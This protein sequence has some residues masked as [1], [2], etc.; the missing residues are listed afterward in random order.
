MKVESIINAMDENE[1][2]VA[3]DLLFEWRGNTYG[4]WARDW[5]DANVSNEVGQAL[6]AEIK[7]TDKISAIKGV[8]NILG[9]SLPKAKRFVEIVETYDY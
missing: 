8:R 1:K 6:I 2:E 4:V 9:I 3:L 5:L 7:S